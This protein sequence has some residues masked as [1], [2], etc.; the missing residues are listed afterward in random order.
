MEHHDSPWHELGF[1]TKPHVSIW[2]C[3]SMGAPQNVWLI[4]ENPMEMDKN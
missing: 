2:G 4:F 1:V 3:P